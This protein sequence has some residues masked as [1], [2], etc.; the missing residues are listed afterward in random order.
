MPARTLDPKGVDYKIQ[1]RLERGMSANEDVGP[2]G[3]DREIPHCVE[4]S[5]EQT[6]FKNLEGK[7]KRKAQIGQYRT[8]VKIYVESSLSLTS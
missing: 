6:R 1:H 8:F 3:M 4:T 2:K 5:P 7:L